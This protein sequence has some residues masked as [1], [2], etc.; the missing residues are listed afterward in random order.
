MFE[1]LRPV[2]GWFVVAG[3]IVLLDQWTKGLASA[4][5]QYAQ[6]VEVLPVFNLTL[7][8]NTG[9]AFSFL[10]NAGGWQ[11]WFFSAVAVVAVVAMETHN[12]MCQTATPPMNPMAQM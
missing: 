3:V 1:R 5:L 11:R 9:A 4:R 8:H 12:Q 2:L 7:Q 6:P 10:H